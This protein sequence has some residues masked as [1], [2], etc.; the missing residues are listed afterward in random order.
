MLPSSTVL[1]LTGAGTVLTVIFSGELGHLKAKCS[2][3]PRKVFSRWCIK[4]L[5]LQQHSI[6][7]FKSKKQ[8]SLSSF[9]FGKKA[10]DSF[11]SDVNEDTD[12]MY[13]DLINNY[14][15]VVFSR[16]DKKPASAEIDDD[17]E[18]LSCFFKKIHLSD[19]LKD[20]KLHK[21]L[22]KQFRNNNIKK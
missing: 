22:V 12:D 11:F 4:E 9:A 21:N 5:Y 2:P 13:E 20:D 17:A 10:E 16:K 1:S 7:G 15:K 18:S 3:R 19:Y 14:G 6:N 8:I